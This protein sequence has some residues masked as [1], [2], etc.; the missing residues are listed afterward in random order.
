MVDVFHHHL[1]AVGDDLRYGGYTASIDRRYRIL[2][3][4]KDEKHILGIVTQP[5]SLSG[6]QSATISLF[7]EQVVEV[8]RDW[9]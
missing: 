9:A 2:C 1:L 6:N 5:P 3:S 7:K 8:S 4:G